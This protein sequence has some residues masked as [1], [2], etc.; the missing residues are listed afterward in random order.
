MEDVKKELFKYG[1]CDK[2]IDVLSNKE[3]IIVCRVLDNKKSYI[4]KY[5]Y[6]SEF[7]REIR[8]Y[9][10]L[11]GLGI[12]TIDIY[13]QTSKSLLLED[14][15]NNK[16][17]RLA[18][19]EDLNDKKIVKSIAK[20]Y[21]NLHNKGEI[22]LSKNDIYLYSELDLLSSE[23]LMMLMSKIRNNDYS[24]WNKIKEKIENSKEY[25]KNNKTITYND[26]YYGNLIIS[27]IKD[28]AYMFDYNLM[29]VGFKYLDI[30]NVL[31]GFNNEM[32]NVFLAEYGDINK[33]EIEL[34]NV[35]S[36]IIGLIIAYSKNEFPKWGEE[37]KEKLLSDE[38]NRLINSK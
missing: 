6:N 34:S 28:N 27:N 18:K 23:N 12:K 9:N 22:F 1:I 15:N 8:W 14:I 35:L 13:G 21:R 20:Y 38:Y 24:F 31:Y 26:F 11:K 10:I 29:G 33:T 7:R 2:S 16:E 19:K 37:I 4:I 30:S 32:K 5:F 3:G 36:P 17:Y 25:L